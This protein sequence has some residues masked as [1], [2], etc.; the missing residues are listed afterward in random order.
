MKHL[1]RADYESILNEV[2]RLMNKEDALVDV[3][4]IKQFC[5]EY[6]Y[7][8]P[9]RS[10]LKYIR[11]DMI[12][13]QL[14]RLLLKTDYTITRPL[15]IYATSYGAKCK[16]TLVK[17]PMLSDLKNYPFFMSDVFGTV[18]NYAVIDS[19]ESV[20][21]GAGRTLLET[22]L[23]VL[24]DMPVVIQAGYLYSGDY[25]SIAYSDEL[26]YVPEELAQIYKSFGFVDINYY[27]GNY[28][29]SIIMMRCPD[30]SKLTASAHAFPMRIASILGNM[31]SDKSIKDVLDMLPD[32][33]AELDN[34]ALTEAVKTAV[35]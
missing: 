24:G 22:V 21:E 18:D 26:K 17:N 16:V 8:V 28:E 30:A 33:A 5:S 11:F 2:K 4:T 15:T 10:I 32:S 13:M 35:E 23:S 27:F 7:Q 31:K 12:G 29:D 25:D 1:D 14:L 3:D 34:E 6:F 9:A 19:L 20:R